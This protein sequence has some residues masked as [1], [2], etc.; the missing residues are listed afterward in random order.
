FKARLE[1]PDLR[2]AVRDQAAKWGPRLILVEDAASGIAIQQ[3]LRRET[4]LPVV[5]MIAAFM[6][7][8]GQKRVRFRPPS[9]H[10]DGITTDPIHS[11]EIRSSDKTEW[12]HS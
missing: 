11:T 1:T 5:P 9:A 2:R 3:M 12:P 10:Q 6:R 8:G 7:V 4:R